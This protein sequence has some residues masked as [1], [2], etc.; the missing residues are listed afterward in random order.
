QTTDDI[1]GHVLPS[2]P[3]SRSMR[4]CSVP[5]I[6]F[7]LVW[8][9]YRGRTTMSL[10]FRGNSGVGWADDRKHPN[11]RSSATLC[12]NAGSSIDRHGRRDQALCRPLLSPRGSW[13]Q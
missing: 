12:T 10:E 9:T 3:H 4:N 13:P 1:G 6:L 2:V 11:R 8:P 7:V 5:L